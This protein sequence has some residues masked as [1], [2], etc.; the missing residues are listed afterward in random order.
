MKVKSK[1]KEARSGSNILEKAPSPSYSSKKVKTLIEKLNKE[2]E[3]ALD[4]IKQQKKH[5]SEK[6]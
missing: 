6:G 2:Q 4:L 3:I 5:F 1:G